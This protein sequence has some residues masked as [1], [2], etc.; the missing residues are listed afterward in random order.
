M[1]LRPNDDD[2]VSRGPPPAAKPLF[3][4]GDEGAAACGMVVGVRAAN[5]RTAIADGAAR[6]SRA[7]I[8]GLCGIT[9]CRRPGWAGHDALLQRRRRHCRCLVDGVVDF[10]S[11]HWFMFADFPKFLRHCAL[12]VQLPLADLLIFL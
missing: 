10:T 5:T 2:D 12:Y 1:K 3:T 11:S 8:S 4:G 6:P 9:T 7:E